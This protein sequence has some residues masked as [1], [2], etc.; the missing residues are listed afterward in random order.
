[1]TFTALCNPIFIQVIE[2]YH[3]TDNVNTPI[4]NPYPLK[5]SNIIFT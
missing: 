3:K 1:M 4:N 2:D 5:V